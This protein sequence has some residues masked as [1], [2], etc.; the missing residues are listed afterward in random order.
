MT[1]G[2]RPAGLTLSVLCC[3]AAL[4]AAPVQA[5]KY[6]GEPFHIGVGGRALGRGGAFTASYPEAS[7][8]FWNVAALA[9]LDRPEV[10]AQH[11]EAFGSLLNHDFVAVT[12]PARDDQGWAWGAY[13][14]YLGGGGILLTAYDSTTGEARVDSEARHGDWSVG[15]GLARAGPRWWSWGVVVKAIVRDIPQTSGWGL[16]LDLGWWGHWRRARFGVKF[17]D[18]TTTFLSYNTGRQETVVPHINWGG[19]ID[20]PPV[21]DGVTATVA[22]EAETY[23]ENRK[24]VAQYWMGATSVDLHLGLEVGYRDRLFGRIGS[25]AGVLA[26]G[27][28][29]VVG[30]W[31]IDAAMTDHDFLDN[32][33]RVSL[34]FLLR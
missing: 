13:G 3:L 26:I 32:T 4:D 8:I 22:A 28:G 21:A 14:T 20:L 25:D 11:A 16:G 6:A 29:F 18:I 17:A 19:E 30:R 24:T 33:Y 1:R 34:R 5:T 23:F 15:F 10:M 9:A 7:S 12:V 2:R 31:G 27:A